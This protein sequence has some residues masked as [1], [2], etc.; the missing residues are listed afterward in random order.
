MTNQTTSPEWEKEFD[1][2]FTMEVEGYNARIFD[3]IHGNV[4]NVKDFIKQ[5]LSQ[6]VTEAEEKAEMRGFRYGLIHQLS[7]I[8]PSELKEKL[9]EMAVEKYRQS[10][11][12]PH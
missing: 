1:R 11:S 9:I 8:P 6:V 10:L 4:G 5:T 2:R 3:S 12:K 7:V